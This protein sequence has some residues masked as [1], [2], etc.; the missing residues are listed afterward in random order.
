MAPNSN[1][2]A[3]QMLPSK[4][5]HQMAALVLPFDLKKVEIP[6]TLRLNYS[7][8]Q[9]TLSTR[10]PLLARA[11]SEYTQPKPTLLHAIYVASESVNIFLGRWSMGG[12]KE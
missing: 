1:K 9:Q 6:H 11:P 5:V 3:A 10:P 12:P 4:K 7:Q 2:Q 8:Q